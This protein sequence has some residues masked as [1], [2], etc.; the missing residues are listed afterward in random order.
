MP[1]KPSSLQLSQLCQQAIYSLRFLFFFK[2]VEPFEHI[3]LPAGP[4]ILGTFAPCSDHSFVFGRLRCVMI[5][6]VTFTLWVCGY[7]CMSVV[8]GS[9]LVRSVQRFVTTRF[10]GVCDRMHV[11]K[12]MSA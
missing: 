9:K 2:A 5:Q 8:I 10:N 11:S 6:L 1:L 7:S 4:F 3:M 12:E